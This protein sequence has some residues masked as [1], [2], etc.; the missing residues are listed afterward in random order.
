MGGRYPNHVTA[1]TGNKVLDFI[2]WV[3][4][5]GGSRTDIPKEHWLECHLKHEGHKDVYGRLAWDQ[6]ANTITSGCTN[7][8]KGRFVHPEQHRALTFRE[9]AA[10]QGF[11]DDF[12][13]C[14]QR[15]AEQIGNAVP[16]PLA[17]AI[18]E[19][20]IKRFLVQSSPTDIHIA[21]EVGIAHI[22]GA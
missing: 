17:Q 6:P 3:P 7:P 21:A 1:L 18:A 19:A 13:F 9:A 4:P 20:L 5:N 12:V 15:I 22:A 11:P 16:P 10:L 8:S 14:G 2:K